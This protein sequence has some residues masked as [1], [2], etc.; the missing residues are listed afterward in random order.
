MTST[1]WS[2]GRPGFSPSTPSI[3]PGRKVWVGGDILMVNGKRH[4]YIRNSRHEAHRAGQLLTAACGFPVSALG[5]VVPVGA[6]AVVINTPPVDVHVVRRRR[7]IAWLRGLPPTLTDQQTDAIFE[8]A[9]RSTTWQ[10][11]R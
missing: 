6:A 2:S 9:R 1:T 8:A 4:P 5:V 7:L 3:T 10:P 11:T